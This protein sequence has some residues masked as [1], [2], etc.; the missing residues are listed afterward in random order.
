[1]GGGGGA[2]YLGTTHGHTSTQLP[3]IQTIADWIHL[4]RT[5]TH[6][7]FATL[8]DRYTDD[9]CTP[10]WDVSRE[11]LLRPSHIRHYAYGNWQSDL[12]IRD[13]LD[14]MFKL[15]RLDPSVALMQQPEI[16]HVLFTG[17]APTRWSRQYYFSNPEGGHQ[18]HI[19]TSCGVWNNSHNHFVTFYLCADYWSLQ[20]PLTDL[21][22]PPHRMHAKLH[23]A[24]RESFTARNLPVP[25]SHHTDSYHV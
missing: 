14:G 22:D 7:E 11:A 8:A 17:E 10:C 16:D 13:C 24:L 1:M 2:L 20:E 4:L 21:T 15:L 18:I 12:D 5:H 3:T 19:P 9:Q 6:E 25:P 23:R